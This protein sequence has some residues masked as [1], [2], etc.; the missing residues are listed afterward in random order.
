[1]T[2]ARRA[3]ALAALAAALAASARPSAAQG[4]VPQAPLRALQIALAATAETG[5]I[6]NP[7]YQGAGDSAD[8]VSRA[9]LATNVVR[10]FAR[11][12]LSVSA[13]G[14]A[15]RFNADPTLPRFV[16]GAWAD[17]ERRL[18]P[19]LTLR[20]GVTTSTSLTRGVSLA[21]AFG[22]PADVP[23]V[24]IP[25]ADV[26]PLLP[27]TRTRSSAGS[28]GA[29][30]RLSER[31]TLSAEGSGDRVAFD[32]PGFAGG[33]GVRARVQ[34]A[35][36]LAGGGALGA[37]VQA[38]RLA[39]GERTLATEVATL[40][41]TARPRGGVTLQLRAGASAAAGDSGGRALRPAGGAALAGRALRGTWDV[42]YARGVSPMPGVGQVLATD[43][44]GAAYVRAV[45]GGLVL[46]AGVEQTWASAPAFGPQRLVTVSSFAD[47]QRPLVGGLW[48]GA[49]GS[50]LSRAQGATVR[51]RDAT[52]RAGYAHVW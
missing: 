49:G 45:P 44:V 24:D 30:Y 37:T 36:R 9:R 42:H 33:T 16:Y 14:E 13:A 27:L 4:P 28:L 19:R 41:W 10:R 38:E 20:A 2:A 25:A 15:Q 7:R 34:S 11:G 52:L 46:R 43:Q 50:Q 31:T 32:A 8:V 1:M 48:V 17:A 35:R 47:V 40:E 39:L 3:A 18:T 51:T 5:V 26:L 21:P 23:T 29:A 22:A 6:T 12:V